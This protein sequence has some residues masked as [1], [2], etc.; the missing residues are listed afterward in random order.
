MTYRY[1][2]IYFITLIDADSFSSNAKTMAYRVELYNKT[3]DPP[4]VQDQFAEG[5][6]FL[7]S[8]HTW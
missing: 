7:R 1:L 2:W 8:S 5:L 4:E 3:G 6:Q